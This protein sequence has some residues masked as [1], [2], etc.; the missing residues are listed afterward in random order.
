M[1]NCY[2]LR[3]IHFFSNCQTLIPNNK[4]K[5]NNFCRGTTEINHFLSCRLTEIVKLLSL[6]QNDKRLKLLWFLIWYFNL[7]CIW[8]FANKIVSS[9]SSLLH[10]YAMIN[11]GTLHLSNVWRNG[12]SLSSVKTPH[13]LSEHNHNNLNNISN[14][15]STFVSTIFT[16]Y[17]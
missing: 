4:G 8:C 14:I 5:I 1:W 15:L 7:L 9:I 6:N 10:E 16:M 13:L 3:N 12:Q 17:Y 11:L 2:S